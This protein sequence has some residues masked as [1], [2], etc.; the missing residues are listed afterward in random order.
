MDKPTN[1]DCKPNEIL[2]GAN[3]LLILENNG[4]KKG[5]EKENRSKNPES[6]S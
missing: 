1:K 6:H 3:Y 4:R 2:S 5:S